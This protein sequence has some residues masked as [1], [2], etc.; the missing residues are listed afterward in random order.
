MFYENIWMALIQYLTV[1]ITAF[2]RTDKKFYGFLQTDL[3]STKMINN[4][5][6]NTA[7]AASGESRLTFTNTEPHKIIR[8]SK[9]NKHFPNMYNASESKHHQ[10]HFNTFNFRNFYLSSQVNDLIKIRG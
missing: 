5:Q 6:G 8:I 10:Q 9:T 7:V 4:H 3:I 1:L 2:E